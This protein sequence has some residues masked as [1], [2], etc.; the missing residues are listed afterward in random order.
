MQP[1]ALIRKVLELEILEEQV[2]QQ[3]RRLKQ[4]LQ[5]KTFLY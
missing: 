4:Q 1:T 3:M 5:Q 2:A